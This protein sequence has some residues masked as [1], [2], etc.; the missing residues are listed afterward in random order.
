MA[1]SDSTA[2]PLLEARSV[3]VRYGAVVPVRA[4]DFAIHPSEVVVICGPSGGGKSTFLRTFNGLAHLES[5]SILL[6]NAPVSQSAA[7]I[8]QLRQQVGMV[9]QAFYLYGHLNAQQNVA[10]GLRVV[11][12][13]SVA[14]AMER[15]AQELERVGLSDKLGNFPRQLSGGQQQRV[16]IA[17][18]LAMDPVA[19]L[20]DEPTSALDPEMIGEVLQVMRGLAKGGMTMLVVTHEMGFARAV[21]SR[22]CFYDDGRILEEATPEAFFERPEHPRLQK[23][24]DRILHPMEASLE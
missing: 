24:L 8:A 19:M 21:G 7:G 9:F 5:G 4:V 15:A 22:V 17:R 20:F 2:T 14:T 3:T 11:R 12:Q 13:L 18:A 10:L 16:A 6:R 1:P 23:F